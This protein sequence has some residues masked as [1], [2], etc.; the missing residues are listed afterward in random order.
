MTR[1]KRHNFTFMLIRVSGCCSTDTFEDFWSCFY[2]G[3]AFLHPVIKLASYFSLFSDDARRDLYFHTGGA[4]TFALI[5]FG[6][7]RSFGC[8]ILPLFQIL[9]LIRFDL[10]FTLHWLALA[11][12]CLLNTISPLSIHFRC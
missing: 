12:F 7:G 11:H 2:T 4:I 8:A 10:I 6:C 9:K 5:T 1:W 3:V